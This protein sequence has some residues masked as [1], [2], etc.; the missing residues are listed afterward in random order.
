MSEKSMKEEIRHYALNLGIDD[1]G[2][3]KTADY[4]SSKSFELR[5][6]MPS[7]KTIIVMVH[8]ELTSCESPSSTI[9][10][11]GRLDLNSFQR[12]CSYRLARFIE[13]RFNGK[14]ASLPYSIPMELAQDR[15]G[16][17][18]F[19]QRHAAVAAGL[20]VLGRHNL[21][22]HPR[23]G[24]RVAITSL[25]TDLVIPEDPKL[26]EALCINCNL[27]V[28]NCPAHALDEAGKT[29]VPKCVANSQPY[30]MRS[31]IV[32]WKKFAAGSPEEQKEMIGSKEFRRINQASSIGMQYYCFNCM[33]VC[34]VG[35]RR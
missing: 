23:F 10:M 4:H 22:L 16:L 30:G 9:A 35:K 13:D 2:F 27:C 34:P 19:S 18:D 28:T 5:R 20:G 7:S 6:F 32:F 8:K 29:D 24:T 15:L 12:S 1:I 26:E 21:L 3:A 17:A 33:M 31:N 14:V 11:N 25:L